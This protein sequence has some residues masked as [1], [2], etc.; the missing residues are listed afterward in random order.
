[1]KI[2]KWDLFNYFLIG[3]IIGELIVWACWA[4]EILLEK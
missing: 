2:T 1:M 3:F 4:I